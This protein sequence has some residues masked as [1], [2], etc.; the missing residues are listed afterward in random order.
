MGIGD[1]VAVN[2][3]LTPT[4]AIY[5]VP[6]DNTGKTNG[7]WNDVYPGVYYQLCKTNGPGV[8]TL[9]TNGAISQGEWWWDGHPET[10][11][12]NHVM[13]PNLWSCDDSNNVWVND[14]AAATASSRHPGVVNLALCD[15]SV[16][17]VKSSV[18]VQVWWALGTHRRGNG[19]VGLLLSSKAHAIDR[20]LRGRWA[21]SAEADEYVGLGV[22]L[23]PGSPGCSFPGMAGVRE[24]RNILTALEGFSALLIIKY[25][26]NFHDH[27]FAVEAA[28]V[29]VERCRPL[30][31]G[32][33]LRAIGPIAERDRNG[34]F[35]NDVVD[36][37]PGR[38]LERFHPVRPGSTVDDDADHFI[39]IGDFRRG[40]RHGRR[41]S[42]TGHLKRPKVLRRVL[43]PVAD[44]VLDRVQS[45]ALDSVDRDDHNELPPPRRGS[46]PTSG[47][48]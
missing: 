38:V 39:A 22:A 35:A 45:S 46:P 6:I 11:L 33:D 27:F 24:R 36:N 30:A 13:P 20:S 19:L 25:P 23:F 4:S 21:W 48:P 7:V 28:K 12:Y 32:I 41:A 34:Y 8:G 9:S 29:D 10:G 43:G 1:Q 31:V 42:K 40:R 26:S 2:D 16:R 47:E 15:G 17:A 37:V 5:G 44:S 3:P 14:G 18:S